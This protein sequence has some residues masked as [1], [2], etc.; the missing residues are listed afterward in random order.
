MPR[1]T[2]A[3][4]RAALVAAGVAA[5][6]FQV[7]T[8]EAAPRVS[9]AVARA[10]ADIVVLVGLDGVVPVFA[11]DG[12]RVGK[13]GGTITLPPGGGATTAGD[14]VLGAAPAPRDPVR[15]AAPDRGVMA[16]RLS[17]KVTLVGP[18]G[19]IAVDGF[20]SDAPAAGTL[21]TG[22]RDVR[23]GARLVLPG[24]LPPGV[25]AGSYELTLENN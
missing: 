21:W 19:T 14:V 22:G 1:G 3:P 7:G 25:Y 4:R 13:A 11:V 12:V 17:S 16:M 2:S 18:A 24:G 10:T 8:A 6:A 5:L 20:A 9:R 23:V 15:L